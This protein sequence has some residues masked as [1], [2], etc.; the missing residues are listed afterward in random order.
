[1]EMMAARDRTP[2]PPSSNLFQMGCQAPA[3]LIHVRVSIHVPLRCDLHHAVPTYR[4]FFFVSMT[5]RARCPPPSMHLHPSAAWEAPSDPSWRLHII[6]R[7]AAAEHAGGQI[8]RPGTGTTLP[9]ARCD[10]VGSS[11]PS[12]LQPRIQ[13]DSTDVIGLVP[14]L[15]LPP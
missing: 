3:G 9:P 7:A 11:H 6:V 10:A 14:S 1:M 5:P 2:Y 15:P 13:R 12:G 4:G 8:A